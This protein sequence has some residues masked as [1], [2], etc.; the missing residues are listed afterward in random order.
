MGETHQMVDTAAD[1]KEAPGLEADAYLR[2]KNDLWALALQ[3][4]VKRGWNTA[5]V[6]NTSTPHHDFKRQYLT[7]KSQG[8][9]D[10]DFYRKSY[11]DVV[12]SGVD[13]L[14]HYI[15]FGDQ[16]GRWP[17]AVFNPAAY[18]RQLPET[19]PEGVC[20][21]YHYA[22]L[23]EVLGLRT[24]GG[25]DPLRYLSDRPELLGHV[26]HPLMHYLQL[27]RVQGG[28]LHQR[29]RLPTGQVPGF[30]Q[31]V[32]PLPAGKSSTEHGIN[33]I[34]PLDRVSG[35]GVSCRGYWAGLKATG[36]VAL[37]SQARQDEFAR[38][39]KIA[40]EEP[41]PGWLDRAQVNLVHMNGDT[42]PMM[43][44]SDG[45]GIMS[46]RYN[47]GVWYWELPALRPEWYASLSYFDEFWAPTAFIEQTLRGATAKPVH[48]VPPYL[49]SLARMSAR[50][51]AEMQNHFLYCFDANSILE[52]K[53]PTAL[54]DAFHQAFPADAGHDVSLVFK[55]TYPDMNNEVVQRLYAASQADARVRIVDT[56]LSDDE[57]EQLIRSALAYVSPHRSEGL[58]LTVVEAMG[59]GVPVITSSFSGLSELVTEDLCFPID[60]QYQPIAQDHFPYPRDFVWSEPSVDAMARQMAYVFNHPE[61]ARQK[62]LKAR[63]AV[64]DHFASDRLVSVY[65][66]HL[67]RLQGAAPSAV[68]TTL[69]PHIHS[70][71]PPS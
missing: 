34:G 5:E 25:F 15:E 20:A 33:V 22:V 12:A 55:I 45:A 2:L 64:V 31:L 68:P 4:G 21:L 60:Y 56:L 62:A 30:H 35:L 38:Q 53:N 7:L 66:D 52:R 13:G 10:E 40:T 58:G 61:Q 57:L 17:N 1:A 16:E 36:L 37:G 43:M 51:P 65:A 39:S 8:I 27:G 71:N 32:R 29:G 47:I 67:H 24:G 6:M 26:D 44:A 69:H 63:E 11:K 46:G 48:R 14:A 23:G 42:L 49:A 28:H 50:G 41:L 18:R 19:P 54:L 3:E 70:E 9:F 59:A